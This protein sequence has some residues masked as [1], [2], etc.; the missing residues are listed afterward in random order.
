M[1]VFF[2]IAALAPGKQ[3]GDKISPNGARQVR[4]PRTDHAHTVVVPYTSL[5]ASVHIV[6]HLVY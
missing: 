6:Q 3:V 4:Q 1:A 2:L 5:P